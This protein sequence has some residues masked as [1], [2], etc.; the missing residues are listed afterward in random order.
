MTCSILEHEGAARPVSERQHFTT[1]GNFGDIV[2]LYEVKVNIQSVQAEK[3]LQG[4]CFKNA[5]KNKKE[6]TKNKK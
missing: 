5:G 6:Q 2:G 1:L 4:S 3:S